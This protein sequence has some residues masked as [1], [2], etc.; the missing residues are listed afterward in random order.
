MDKQDRMKI[1][2]IRMKYICAMLTA[3]G[4]YI[5]EKNSKCIIHEQFGTR[6]ERGMRF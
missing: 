5:E 2:K 6:K 1:N 4:M 3:G